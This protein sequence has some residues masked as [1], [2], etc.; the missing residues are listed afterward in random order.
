MHL[1]NISY[2][3]GRSF[4]FDPVGMKVI[5][6]PEAQGMLTKEYRKPFVLPE[7]V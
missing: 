2:K 7:N 1:C 6:D 3:L 5:N 4:D